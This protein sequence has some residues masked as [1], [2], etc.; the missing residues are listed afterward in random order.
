MYP[1]ESLCPFSPPSSAYQFAS[2][3]KNVFDFWGSFVYI[4]PLIFQPEAQ[5]VQLS[6]GYPGISR[7]PL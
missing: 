5:I 6:D 2:Y 1:G 3:V 7:M 4:F